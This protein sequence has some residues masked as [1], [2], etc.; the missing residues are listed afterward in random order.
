MLAARSILRFAA[1]PAVKSF[2]AVQFT[3]QPYLCQRYF[4]AYKKEKAPKTPFVYDDSLDLVDI[5]E[6]A[7]SIDTTLTPE[8]KE[9]V[10]KIKKK[11]RGN[12]ILS[13]RCETISHFP[14]SPS[15]LAVNLLPFHLSFSHSP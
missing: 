5:Q 1:Q 8:Q 13:K 3:A 4:G 15:M 2:P 14:P 10:D 7:A 12:S 9:Y 11:I 6:I